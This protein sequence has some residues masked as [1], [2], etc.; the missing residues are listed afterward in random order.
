MPYVTGIERR[1]EARGRIEGRAEGRVEGRAEMILVTLETRFGRV[2]AKV[3]AAVRRVRDDERLI[4]LQR[5]AVS[6][7]AVG[8]FVRELGTGKAERLRRRT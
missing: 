8:D 6:V 5:L 4:D 2:P 3:A 1:A 7:A